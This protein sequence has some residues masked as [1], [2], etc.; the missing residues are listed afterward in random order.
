[1]EMNKHGFKKR[2]DDNMYDVTSYTDKELFNILDLDSPTD[3]ELE[4]KIIFLIK[5]YKN[6]QNESGDQ[7][8]KFF[9]DIYR[10]FFE[11]DESESESESESEYIEEGFENRVTNLD[12]IKQKGHYDVNKYSIAELDNIL[13][14]D[15]KEKSLNDINNIINNADNAQEKEFLEKVYIYYSYYV[16]YVKKMDDLKPEGERKLSDINDMTILKNIIDNTEIKPSNEAST[17]TKLQN[18]PTN[19]I[20][21]EADIDDGP[22]KTGENVVYSKDIE[23]ASGKLN[24]ILQQTVKRVISIDSQYRDDKT[25][26]STEFTFNLSDPLKDV[27]SLKLYSVQIPYTWYTINNNFGSNFFVLKGDVD[28]INNGNHDYQVE[29]KAGNYSPQ[30]LTDAINDSILGDT[31]TSIKN[32]YTDV[33]FGTTGLEYNKFNSK[34]TTNI[35]LY[36]Q[37]NETSYRLEFPYWENPLS[38]DIDERKQSIPGFLG[39]QRT[40]YDFYSVEGD[41][42][43]SDPNKIFVVT[44]DKNNYF[45]IYKY[46]GDEYDPDTKL[47]LNIEES[48]RIEIATGSLPKS[49]I[50]ENLNTAIKNSIKLSTNE[51]GIT[52]IE[53]GTESY[54]KLALKL[55]RNTTNNISKSK[56]QIQFPDEGLS[57]AQIWTGLNSCFRFKKTT[58]NVIEMNNVISDI[59]PLQQETTRYNVLSNPYI[60]IKCN[61]YGYNV[62]TNDYKIQ[63]SNTDIAE[64]YNLGEYLD[65]IRNGFEIVDNSSTILSD[66]TQINTSDNRL[67]VQI[68]INKNIT[69]ENFKIDLSNSFLHTVINFDQSYNLSTS[70]ILTSVFPYTA[71]YTIPTDPDLKLLT[72]SALNPGIN[73]SVDL[74][75][76]VDHPEN[77]NENN[78]TTPYSTGAERTLQRNLNESL[79][80][81][82]ELAGSNITLTKR[83]GENLVDATL[84]I[85]ITKQLTEEDFSIQF[86]ED[87]SFNITNG[88]FQIDVS[89]GLGTGEVNYITVD[90]TTVPN[91]Y[92]LQNTTNIEDIGF[93]NT[94]LGLTGE[95][96]IGIYDLS[97][98]L[99]SQT[100]T[101]QITNQETFTIDNSNIAFIRITDPDNYPNYGISTIY[102]SEIPYGYLIPAPTA[103]EYTDISEL[104]RELNN[105]FNLFPDLLGTRIELVV[106]PN[107]ENYIDCSFTVS[108]NQN[109]KQDTW[110]K[111]FNIDRV[112]INTPFNLLNSELEPLHT[113]INNVTFTDISYNYIAEN[114]TTALGVKGYKKISQNVFN[115]TEQNNTFRLIAIDEGVQTVTNVNDIEITLPITENNVLIE[116]TR[117]TLL[118]RLNKSFLG[119]IADGSLI[120]IITDESGIEYT[121][122]RITINKEYTTKDYRIVFYDPFSFVSCFPGV[123][124]VRNATWDTTLGW[125]LGFREATIYYLSDTYSSDTNVTSIEADTGIS[126]NLFNYFLITLDDYNQNRLNDGLV[127]ISTKDT[128]TALP[129]YMDRAKLICDP[130]TKELTYNPTTRTDYS[131]LTQKQLY[132]ITEQANSNNEYVKTYGSGPFAKDVFGIIPMKLAGLQNGQSFVEFGGTLQNQER[133][134]F[135]PVNLKRMTVKL[136]SDRG[137]VVDLNGANWSFSLICEQLHKPAKDGV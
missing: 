135:G 31:E 134:Y 64:T 137:N 126:T 15:T 106:S 124:S 113:P 58:N 80:E 119:T 81:I 47:A 41:K 54:F 21:S 101:S 28:G 17:V 71:L 88:G 38:N 105:Q 92:S 39:F 70:N 37:Y 94:T 68:D 35:D 93:L 117:N 69:Q 122:M 16:D 8:A 55:N 25:T 86:L 108:I 27:V 40:E 48:I 7:L 75:Y 42:A 67:N 36:K 125:I 12:I 19:M 46:I 96:G 91:T 111:N 60:Y 103:R 2:N 52:R 3:R 11:T 5:K 56:L 109:Y 6:M 87:T 100:F 23:F 121:K 32:T 85:L 14:F 29:I 51:S 115:C 102:G 61:E 114:S 18:V 13:G 26:L 72:I 120:S 95:N 112:M 24:P 84:T 116:Y 90:G 49:Q 20:K 118:E 89:G 130:V 44:A 128:E 66:N 73:V 98:A 123:N 136:I 63:I 99:I 74:K 33:S 9:E 43:S 131:N 10:H 133:T 77:T 65:Q 76:E 129:S 110:Y 22:D 50:I 53:E 83:T 45:T 78:G 57:S 4:A 62:P 97:Q 127:T 79:S 30:E 132:T 59:S 107:D 34:I 104:E 1:M 82:P